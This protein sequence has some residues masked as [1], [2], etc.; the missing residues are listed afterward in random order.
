MADTRNDV[1]LPARTWVDLYTASDIDSGTSV[2]IYNKGSYPC[3]VAIKVDKPDH[4]TFGVPLYVGSMGSYAFI[5]DGS[6]GLWGYSEMGTTVLVQ[7]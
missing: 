6:S 1:V 5:P 2:S 7:E 3:Q 4:S